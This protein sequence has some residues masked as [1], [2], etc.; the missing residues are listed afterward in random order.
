MVR[1]FG[2]R[3]RSIMSGKRAPGKLGC[4]HYCS[5]LLN[6]DLLRSE[7]TWCAA[8]STRICVRVYTQDE[9]REAAQR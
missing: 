9:A 8:M 3:E 7:S 6:P 1:R 4:E 2:A 5:D